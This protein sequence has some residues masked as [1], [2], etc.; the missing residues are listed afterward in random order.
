MRKKGR[1]E[2]KKNLAKKK[3]EKVKKNAS[4]LR[5]KPDYHKVQRVH[6]PSQRNFTFC[7]G[8]RDNYT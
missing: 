2:Q 1:R 8:K 7:F 5:E 4:H 3:Y 6:G